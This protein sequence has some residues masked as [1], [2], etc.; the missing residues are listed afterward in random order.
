MGLSG[1]DRLL[2]QYE[3]AHRQRTRLTRHARAPGKE[4]APCEAH[5]GGLS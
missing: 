1:Q 2:A 3:D 4:E 5:L